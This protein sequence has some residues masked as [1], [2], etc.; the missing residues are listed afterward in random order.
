[1]AVAPAK[2]KRIIVVIIAPIISSTSLADWY[3]TAFIGDQT[4]KP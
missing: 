1:M 3:L 4:S 2:Q